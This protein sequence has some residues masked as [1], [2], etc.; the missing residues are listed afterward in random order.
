MR[1][2]MQTIVTLEVYHSLKAS[3]SSFNSDLNYLQVFSFLSA[4]TIKNLYSEAG[5]MWMICNSG[6]TGSDF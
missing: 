6:L 1:L 5:L 4:I 2:H 3:G